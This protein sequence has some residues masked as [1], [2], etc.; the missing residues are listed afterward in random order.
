[1]DPL[2]RIEGEIG[3]EMVGSKTI[4][5]SLVTQVCCFFRFFK[6]VFLAA[7][8]SMILQTD[9]EHFALNKSLF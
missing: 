6:N 3:G 2:G 8:G 4:F 9:F 7:V 5:V 1:M